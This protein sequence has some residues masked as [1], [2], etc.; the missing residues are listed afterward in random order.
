MKKIY[1]INNIYATTAG[2]MF[3]LGSL[4]CP[5]AKADTAVPAGNSASNSDQNANYG[6]Q[7]SGGGAGAGGGAGG[8]ASESNGGDGHSDG[9]PCAELGGDETGTDSSFSTGTSTWTATVS[10]NTTSTSTSTDASAS[11]GVT[12]TGSDRFI[13]HTSV[14]N[15]KISGTCP[16]PKTNQP[17]GSS[18]SKIG[19]RGNFWINYQAVGGLKCFFGMAYDDGP[20]HMGGV[21]S[22]GSGTQT[23]TS[24]AS[25]TQ[26]GTETAS[27]THTGTSTSSGTHTGTSTSSG[28][29]TS[30]SSIS[31]ADPAGVASI[32]GG[33]W[34]AGDKSPG[35]HLIGDYRRYTYRVSCLQECGRVITKL[36]TVCPTT[37]GCSPGTGPVLGE[38]YSDH[39]CT[40]AGRLIEVPFVVTN[41]A[42]C[43]KKVGAANAMP[44][45]EADWMHDTSI[46]GANQSMM[47]S[48]ATGTG[49]A[50][51]SSTA[52]GS[53][54]ATDIS[55]DIV[56]P[57]DPRSA[58]GVAQYCRRLY[59]NNISEAGQT[60]VVGRQNDTMIG[61]STGTQTTSGTWTDT[62]TSTSTD[63]SVKQDGWFG[64]RAAIE[65]EDYDTCVK[66]VTQAD[67]IPPESQPWFDNDQFT[68]FDVDKT[69]TPE[70]YCDRFFP[71]HT[72]GSSGGLV[73]DT[74][75][76]TGTGTATSTS[77]STNN[78][79]GIG[80]GI[81]G[82]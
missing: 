63:H 31:V 45:D 20:F 43:L 60:I 32:R 76:F 57:V 37:K 79:P 71:G 78:S 55:T 51:S 73:S 14:P 46:V 82:P 49:T 30:T 48:T 68:R 29:A 5:V 56:A 33:A 61:T 35:G 7:G 70:V 53:S 4:I 13:G 19:T 72:P 41:Y 47:T 58:A 28:T 25:G 2:L 65:V 44:P 16:T 52:T 18:S 80:V 77:T 81:P 54:T 3:L 6:S 27:G 15:I 12:G 17:S 38:D 50:L 69:V 1:C 62:A 11:S 42:E 26:T 34:L 22:D 10:T 36:V 59:P 66:K 24:T 40:K 75:T 67:T 21:D 64:L 74:F 23:G 9:G 39:G 8:G